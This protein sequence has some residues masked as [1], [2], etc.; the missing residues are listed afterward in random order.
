LA[1]AFRRRFRKR[2]SLPPAFAEAAEVGASLLKG[3]RS[4]SQ[5]QKN[6]MEEQN[7]VSSF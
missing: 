4:Q 2:M 5:S 7:E 3:R 6:D 1:D